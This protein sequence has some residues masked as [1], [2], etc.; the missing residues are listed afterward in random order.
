MA[1]KR[2]AA[3]RAVALDGVADVLVTTSA[4]LGVGVELAGVADAL[5]TT[6]AELGTGIPLSGDAVARV[7]ALAF[8]WQPIGGDAA[9]GVTAGGRI[10]VRDDARDEAL[11][12]MAAARL[13]RR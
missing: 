4:A 8:A 7:A 11:L 3:G 6:S 1:P 10:Q 2:K 12:L 13:F 9:I 5:V